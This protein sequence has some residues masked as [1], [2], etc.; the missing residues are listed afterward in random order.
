MVACQAAEQRAARYDEELRAASAELERQR[1]HAALA[2]NQS[3]D[4]LSSTRDSL[5]ASTD[6]VSTLQR[7]VESLQRSLE[8]A[9]AAAADEVAARLDALSE[10]SVRTEAVSYT[11]LTLPTILRV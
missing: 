11:H 5:H 6:R 4:E 8:V 1:A 3:G 2:I 7:E 10:E 9:S